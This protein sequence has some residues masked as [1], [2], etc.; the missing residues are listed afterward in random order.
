M[1]VKS[2]GVEV[3]RESRR[4][5]LPFKATSVRLDDETLTRVSQMVEAMEGSLVWLMVEAVRL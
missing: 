3:L 4:I 1:K 2:S 5:A